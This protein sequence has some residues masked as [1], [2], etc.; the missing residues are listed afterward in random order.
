M[1]YVDADA[2]PVKAEVEKVATRHRIKAVMVCDGGLRPSQNPW[3]E[4]RYVTEG[5][6]AADDWIVEQAGPGDIVA[7]NDIPLADRALEKGARVLR[8]DGEE[9]TTRNIADRLAARNLSD[10][11]RQDPMAMQKAAPARNADRE[12][13][14]FLNALERMV[15]L[16]EK[17][18]D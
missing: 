4:T 12:K 18:S 7:T 15:R 6:D 11:R 2:C 8:F 13:Q 16:V 3:I 1:I 17:K 9:L 5:L 10:F 14:G